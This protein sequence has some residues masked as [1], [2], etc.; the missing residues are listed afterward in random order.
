MR[1]MMIAFL[2]QETSISEQAL[3]FHVLGFKNVLSY[4]SMPKTCAG[5]ARQNQME[6]GRL[7]GSS[8]PSRLWEREN[9]FSLPV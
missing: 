5:Q 2:T 4:D 3:F 6:E 7:A 1:L 8:S 9:K